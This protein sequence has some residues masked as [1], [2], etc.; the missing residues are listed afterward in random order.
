MAPLKIRQNHSFTPSPPR[1]PKGPYTLPVNVQARINP[2]VFGALLGGTV[3]IFIFAVLFWKIGKYIRSFNR[4]RV[5]REG[6]L[7]TSRYARTWYGWVPWETHQRNKSV[8]AHSFKW[9]LDWL[10]WESSRTDYTWS[11]EPPHADA[12]WNPGPP[13]HCH[14][15]LMG[16]FE[17]QTDDATND[18]GVQSMMNTSEPPGSSHMRML[19]STGTSITEELFTPPEQMDGACDGPYNRQISVSDINAP[20]PCI[21]K[22]LDKSSGFRRYT[23]SPLNAAAWSTLDLEHSGVRVPR[24]LRDRCNTR[25]GQ[26]IHVDGQSLSHC[27]A[28]V[29]EPAMHA[30]RAQLRKCRAWSAK[31]QVKAKSRTL[32]AIRDSSGPPGTPFVEMLTSFLSE[33]SVSEIFMKQKFRSNSRQSNAVSVQRPISIDQKSQ[34]EAKLPDRA[35]KYHT[36][37]V[38]LR[39]RPGQAPEAGRRPTDTWDFP[40]HDDSILSPNTSLRKI[41]LFSRGENTKPS[42][43]M[44]GWS[45]DGLCDWEVKLVDELNR[46]LGWIFDETTPG[47][48]PYQFPLLANHWLNRETW[49]VID[50]VSR[51]PT[52][53]R[54]AWGDPRFN[55]PYPEPT[56]SPRPKY[57]GLIHR[58]AYNPRI[59]SWRA[60]V[61]RQR[62][63]SGLRDAVRTVELYEDSVEEPPDGHLDPGSWMFPRPPQGFEVSTKQKNAWYEGGTGWQETLEDWQH[64]PRGYR[65]RKLLQEGRVN[66]NWVKNVAMKVHR[67]CRSVSH[68]IISRDIERIPSPSLSVS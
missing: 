66:R 7:T 13:T 41:S 46:K 44:I 58:R 38:R 23:D 8:L 52:D 47:Q 10:S 56:Y 61:N 25:T 4:H 55:V 19:E 12:M 49:L 53:S 31:M 17:S 14:G 16:S 67:S 54:R 18:G 68:K 29:F 45:E 40:L 51:V 65:I 63:A 62:K 32:R 27:P 28:Q 33:Q 3:G 6:K 20:M 35:K 15:A 50:P 11:Y 59:D 43:R 9:I 5:L 22:K 36:T 42:N 48:K 57:S 60:A 2:K 1:P 39:P 34:R 21:T 64:V 37:P 24:N 30:R 26:G